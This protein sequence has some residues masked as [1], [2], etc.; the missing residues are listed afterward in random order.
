M[1]KWISLVLMISLMLTLA[2][3][4]LPVPEQ[5]AT[6]ASSAPTTVPTVP[7]QTEPAQTQP[8]E[9]E[10]TEPAPVLTENF[11]FE[12]G[13]VTYN[14]PTPYQTFVDNGW[15][16]VEIKK[17]LSADTEVPGYSRQYLDMVKDGVKIHA[18]AI[19]MSGNMRTVKECNIGAVTVMANNGLGFKM[20]AGITLD[21]TVDEVQA[22]YGP[23]SY[24]DTFDNYTTLHYVLPPHS[25]VIF[26]IY[27]TETEYNAVTLQNMTPS[28]DDYTIPQDRRPEFFDHYIAP[29]KLTN[30]VS[31][32]QFLLDGVLYQLP[33]PLEHFVSNG[34]TVVKDPIVSVGA[35]NGKYGMVLQKGDVYLPVGLFNFDKIELTSNN[36]AVYEIDFTSVYMEGQA[37]EFLRFPGNLGMDTDLESAKKV[38][39]KYFQT[40][41]ISYTSLIRQDKL[42]TWMIRYSFFENGDLIVTMRSKNWTYPVKE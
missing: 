7:T 25:E 36:C 21:I 18:C 9:T 37:P 17:Q 3:C 29:E 34:W 35:G 33:C 16:M 20:D 31:A 15:K 28:E 30:D 19:N 13:G 23:A 14:L 38:C 24:V 10:P 26:Y 22:I 5:S 2:C 4:G 42:G 11:T 6:Q 8:P 40:D 39:K 41:G 1:K 12:I 32:T 27:N